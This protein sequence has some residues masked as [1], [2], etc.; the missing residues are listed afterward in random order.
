GGAGAPF[1]IGPPG[2]AA[3]DA[4]ITAVSRAPD[5]IDIF[6]GMPSGSVQTMQWS[7]GRWS[8]QQIAPGRPPGRTHPDAQNPP[9]TLVSAVSRGPGNVDVFWVDPDD[10]RVLSRFWAGGWNP[11]GP[12]DLAPP[13]SA[14]TDANVAAVSRGPGNLDLFWSAPDGRVVSRFWA[15]DKWNDNGAF[16]V[17]QAPGRAGINHRVAA[18]SR[19][20]N[21]LD[22]FWVGSDGQLAS[23]WWD[24]AWH[25][26]QFGRS[27]HHPSHDAGVAVVSRDDPNLDLFWVTEQGADIA[28]MWFAGGDWHGPVTL[29]PAAFARKG[30]GRWY[31]TLVTLP[32]GDVL[33]AG[34]HPSESDTR[35]SNTTPET[36]VV[37][38]DRWHLHGP[39]GQS[40]SLIQYPRMH[41]LPD[42]RVFCVTPMD[43]T[44]VSLIYDPLT[45]DATQIGGV[46]PDGYRAGDIVGGSNYASVLLPLLKSTRYRPRVLIL[47]KEVALEIDV[48][49]DAPAWTPTSP[50]ALTTPFRSPRRLNANAVIL[51]TGNIFVSGGVAVAGSD[52]DA[53]LTAELYNPETGTWSVLEPARRPRNYHS[54]ALLMPN[55]SVWVAGSNVNGEPSTNEPPPGSDTHEPLIEIYR[56]SYCFT[57][58]PVITQA[59]SHLKYNDDSFTFLCPQAQDLSRVAILRAGSTTHAFDADQRF[60]ELDFQAVGDRVLVARPPSPA[61]APPGAY[62]LF[63][64]DLSLIPSEGH[65]VLV[66]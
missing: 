53:I 48:D 5:T 8:S 25:G 59:R 11:A 55:G 2:S 40:S 22:V 43:G 17:P 54:V 30:G 51:P 52:R 56:P 58:R 49:A 21:H 62:L 6:W 61:I 60:V 34:G 19:D 26:F 15:G 35:H 20:S 12:F 65:F 13:G 10:G 24:G 23:I 63:A 47:G 41:L 42:G 46:L 9:R 37:A 14:H 57:Q 27:Q 31:P 4:E 50:R 33:A 39:L 18:V 32:S 44:N 64:I 45:D 66:G 7:R 36:Y 3:P 16:A 38:K 28:T 29:D 1:E